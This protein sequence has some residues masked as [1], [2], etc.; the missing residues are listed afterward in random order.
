MTGTI[1]I[2]SYGVE[3][4]VSNQA[5]K[6]NIVRFPEQFRFRLNQLENEQPVTDRDR[7][8]SLKLDDQVFF[9]IP[10]KSRIHALLRIS[11]IPGLR[12]VAP[13]MTGIPSW[14]AEKT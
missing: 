7:F 11:W 14:R 10:A 3:T 8:A 1:G 12:Y 13:E 2:L 6:R 9:V 5:V 4:K